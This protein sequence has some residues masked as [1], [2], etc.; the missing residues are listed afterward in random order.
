MKR[1]R[2]YRNR[3]GK[4]STGWRNLVHQ[5]RLRLEPL[6]DRRLLDAGT[7]YVD[8]DAAGAETGENWTDAFSDLQPALAASAAMNADADPANDVAEIWIAEGTYKPSEQLEAGD[9]RTATF[10][11]VAG[12]S[13][14][15]GF[16]GTEATLA[17][18]A[19]S[20]G[21]FQNETILSGDLGT[22]GDASDNAYTVVYA[23]LPAETESALEGLTI[24]RGN[25]TGGPYSSLA[26][27]KA[28]GGVFV[29]GSG[30]LHITESSLS[31]NS[32]DTTGGG[33]LIDNGTVV[34]TDSTLAGNSADGGGAICNTS[35][36]L[37][38][39]NS[40][41]AG[42]TALTSNGRGGG[43]LNFGTVTVDSSTLSGNS[44]SDIGGGIQNIGSLTIS[45]ST[46][47]QNAVTDEFRSGG[48]IYN[49]GTLAIA[50]STFSGNTASQPHSHGGAIYNSSGTGT[51]TDSSFLHNSSGD[52]GGAI[53]NSTGKF[54][55]VNC[56]ISGNRAKQGG[57]IYNRGAFTLINSTLSGNSASIYGGAI[58]ARGTVTIINCSILRNSALFDGGGVCSYH[59]TLTF[60][61]SIV[62][63]NEAPNGDD[64]FGSYDNGS[65]LIGIDPGFVRIPSDGGDGWGDDL[66][67]S[68]VDESVN[69]DYGDLRL[70]PT[71]LAI[72]AGDNELLPADTLD[73]DD[74][75]DTTEPMPVDRKRNSRVVGD[76]VDLGAFEFQAA[77]EPYP[78]LV[79]TTERDELDWTN[80]DVS[81]REA[82]AIAT[83]LPVAT[84]ITFEAPLAD[85]PILLDE[86]LQLEAD[87]QIDA[88]GAG[89]ITI[90]AQG[91]SRI[92]Y[93]A[94]EVTVE[95]DSLHITGGSAERAGGIYNLGELTVTNCTFADNQATGH[96]ESGVGGAIYNRLG[97]LT[98]S[99]STLSQNS[100]YFGGGI[101]NESGVTI[102]ADCSLSNNYSGT[103]GDGGG[104][105]N[106]EGTLKI[107]NSTLTSNAAGEEG[108]GV[109]NNLG[110]M[111]VTDCSF[112]R[113]GA[114]DGGGIYNDGG[115]ITLSNSTLVR[116]RA[117]SD[118]L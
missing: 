98:V 97:T 93:V 62:V 83:L 5:R 94:S 117:Y 21:A 4:H 109:F 80:D 11:L 79:V 66:E 31:N 46:F 59:A 101:Y 54:T 103:Y 116:N 16:A 25:A 41:L 57:G 111:A 108:G 33:I 102:V 60:N 56:A 112:T 68:G 61:N 7:L 55:V 26:Y 114:E 105:Y 115:S 18:R 43:I 19:T 17:E 6:E 92:F 53:A 51:V 110:T 22:D 58:Y 81:L 74:N 23:D 44:A 1:V 45:H 20:D 50:N 89:G 70:A 48:A 107:D 30:T 90:D 91:Q 104:I 15:G 113:N 10:A 65:S 40:T 28:G 36:T 63:M 64:V 100:G 86:Q 37:T 3:G 99:N 2:Q 42:N 118:G 78:D 77:P 34:I 95:L 82:I 49:S 72:N 8:A 67:T 69:D 47:T 84:A 38:V 32:A 73:L 12:V 85:K 13:L 76:A 14:I 27:R 87:M 96:F 9:E 71:S 106:S 75:G 24:T 39:T 29:A 88:A 35:G 52:K